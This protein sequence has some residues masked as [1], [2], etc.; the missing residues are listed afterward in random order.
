MEVE[1][2]EIMDLSKYDCSDFLRDGRAIRIRAIRSTDKLALLE[3]FH[4]LSKE[5]IHSRFFGGKH[6]LTIAEL[7]FFT[8]VDF[9]THVALI[10]EMQTDREPIGVG[11][12]FTNEIEDPLSADIAITVDESSHGLGIGTI[13]FKHLI[14]IARQLQI[15]ELTADVLASNIPMLRIIEKLNIPLKRKEIGEY[16]NIR[17]FL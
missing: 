14:R 11:R 13:L 2:I 9:Q 12:F 4:R 5:S 10:A 6:D 3:G 1:G 7:K 8:E 17:L 16:I 15:K